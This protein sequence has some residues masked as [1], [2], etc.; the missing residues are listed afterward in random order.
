MA[1]V[2]RADSKGLSD[3]TEAELVRTVLDKSLA[4]QA[5]I[6]QCKSIQERLSR[7]DEHKPLLHI[8]VEGRVITPN[9]AKRLLQDAGETG[10]LREPPGYQIISSIGQGSMGMVYRAK[11]LSMDRPVALKIL[12]RQLAMNKEFIER[13]HREAHLAAKLSHNNIVQAIDSG[14]FSGHHY[15]VMEYVD[16]TNIKQEL[17]KGKVYEEKEALRIILQVAEAMDH[18]NQKGLI[19]RANKPDD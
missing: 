2:P 11:Q 3:L 6:D 5:E 19:H 15:F 13:F 9:Q 16:G 7:K 1:T 18:A 4:T 17:D 12:L 14:E 10:K 8:M